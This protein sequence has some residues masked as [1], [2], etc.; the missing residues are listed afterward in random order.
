MWNFNSNMVRLK[1]FLPF[2]EEIKRFHF[3]SN[4]VRLKDTLA[5]IEEAEDIYFNSNMVRLKVR[6]C[7]RCNKTQQI[8]IP[9]WF[10]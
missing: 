1:E 5:Q 8:S 4:M 9:I 3:N 2:F 10:D 7:T 6:Y